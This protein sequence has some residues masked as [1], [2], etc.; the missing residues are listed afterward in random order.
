M[1]K[2]DKLAIVKGRLAKLDGSPKNIK[3][4][5]VCKKLRRQIRN[6]ENSLAE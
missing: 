5:G 2:K 1:D 4:G 6:M 3:C